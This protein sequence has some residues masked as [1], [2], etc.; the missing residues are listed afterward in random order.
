MSDKS[1]SVAAAAAA[2]LRRH[3]FNVDVIDDDGERAIIAVTPAPLP[4]GGDMEKWPDCTGLTG[5]ELRD[6]ER[7]LREAFIK[8]LDLL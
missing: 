5:E 6:C 4:E 3:G 2:V 7:R 1:V 8:S